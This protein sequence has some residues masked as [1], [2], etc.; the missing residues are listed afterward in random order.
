ML[1]LPGLSQARSK[2]NFLLKPTMQTYEYLCRTQNMTPVSDLDDICKIVT[3]S[4][5]CKNVPK[6]NLLQ[7]NSLDKHSQLDAWEFIQGCAEGALNSVKDLLNFFW[8]IMKWAW[9]NTTSNDARAKSKGQATEYLAATKLYLNTEYQKA[10][11]KSSPPMKEM[12]A[13]S[14]M[15][16][17]IGKMILNSITDTVQKNY[18]EFGCLNF[19]AKSEHVCKLVADVVIPP[20]GFVAFLK[21]GPKAVKQFP[22][23]KVLY[24]AEKPAKAK[25]APAPAP[26]PK[27]KTAA[28]YPSK[29][30][31]ELVAKNPALAKTFD[32]IGN[33]VP[34]GGDKI[35]HVKDIRYNLTTDFRAVSPAEMVKRAE[36]LEPEHAKSVL[37]AYNTLNDKK[38]MTSYMEKLFAESAEWMAK[39]GRPEDLANLKKG[40]V[41][42]QAIAV[43]LVK[44]LKDRGDMNFTTINYTG[45][46]TGKLNIDPAEVAKP[47]DRFRTAVKT[48]PFFDNAFPTNK[49]GARG[50]HGRYTHMIQRDMITESLKKSTNGQPQKFWDFMGTKKGINYWV[51]LFDSQDNNSFTRPEAISLFLNHT[52]TNRKLE[53]R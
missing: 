10:L 39:K 7:C 6:K 51:D 19:E 47:N 14:T 12:K 9:D 4:E 2:D 26:A 21:Y 16:G 36:S 17:A 48:G 11:A 32:E 41:T 22:N 37:A 38:A 30:F 20:A 8:E 1:I 50:N 46:K 13:V 49:T 3:K 44:R 23:L 15:S 33:K 5:V 29:A 25:A 27:P 31:G 35:T 52:V 53:D 28:I 34:R 18:R 43:V 42:E 24:Q 45:I 40:V